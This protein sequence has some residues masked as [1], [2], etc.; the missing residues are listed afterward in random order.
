MSAAYRCEQVAHNRYADVQSSTSVKATN[1]HEQWKVVIFWK[2]ARLSKTRRSYRSLVGSRIRPKMAQFK[3]TLRD[4]E[5]D[6][7][8]M[9]TFSSA[10]DTTIVQ[11]LL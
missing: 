7:T 4:R 1:N 2:S 11:Q 9:Q 6:V 10:A 5:S 3:M 8:L